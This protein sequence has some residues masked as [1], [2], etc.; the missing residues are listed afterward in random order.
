MQKNRLDRLTPRWLWREEQGQSLIIVAGAIITLIAVIGLGVDL[1]LAYI[2]RVRLARAMDAAALAAAQELPAEEAAHRRALE[3]LAANGFAIDDTENTCIQTLGSDLYPDPCGEGFKTRITIDTLSFRD[4]PDMVNSANRI[5]VEAIEYVPLTFVRVIGFNRTPVHAGATAENIEDLDIVI[6]YDRSGSMQEDTRCYGCFDVGQY[7]NGTAHP[8]PI[9]YADPPTNTIPIHC[10]PS[11][12]LKWNGTYFIS[13]EAEYYSRYD[14][15]ADY[16]RDWTEYPKMWWA[17]QRTP[18]KKASGLD[19]RGAFMMVGPNSAGAHYYETINDIVNPD[20]SGADYWT[21]PRLEYDFTV[22]QT[23]NYYVW[24]R[25]QGGVYDSSLL[26]GNGR[27]SRRQVYIGLNGVPDQTV[28]TCYWGPYADGASSSV[29]DNAN[30]PLGN[31]YTYSWGWSWSRAP[32]SYYLVAGQT[33]ELDVWAAGQGFRLDKIVI[34][35]NTNTQLDRNGRPLD[36]DSGVPDGGP[37]ETHGRTDWACMLDVDPRFQPYLNGRRDDLYDDYQ[38]IR[39]AKEAAKRFV[40]KLNPD[41]DQIGYVWYSSSADIIDELYCL[42]QGNC[43]PDEDFADIL[44]SIESTY[45]NGGTNIADAM[46]DGIRVLMTGTEPANNGSGFPSKSPGT[47]HYGRP[48]AA[49]VMILMTDGQANMRPTLPWGYGNCYSDDV[50]P[51]IGISSIDLAR[52]CVIWF[53]KQALDS[54]VVIYTIGL[55]GQADN[56]LLQYVADLT[57]GWYYF[58]PSAGELDAI[59]D[60]LYERIFLRLTD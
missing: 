44:S 41:L 17:M 58:A 55:G 33:Y 36:W 16:H 46:W 54:N 20:G 25:A 23:G 59:F 57:G 28:R 52:E 6:V 26:W 35:N 27:E 19:T 8:L 21:T 24:I 49:H 32:N 60:S 47:M 2:E 29:R 10:A 11:E 4:A 34:T 51:D 50:W 7:P 43:A 48:S 53:A 40:Q 45:A 42:R 5:R 30:P 37:W 56:E 22:P 3:Y 13:I 14:T 9:Q 18:Y 12:P 38:P 1:G 39:A 15:A 31:C